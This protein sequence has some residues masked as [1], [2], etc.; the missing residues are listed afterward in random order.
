MTKPRRSGSRDPYYNV[1][2]AS[3]SFSNIAAVLA[4]FALAAVILVVQI[5]DLPDKANAA[6]LRDWATIAFLVALFGCVAS[7]FTFGVLTG[8][9]EPGSRSHAAALFGGTGFAVSTVF[10]FWGLAS[11]TK[12]FLSED[13][14]ELTRW[15]FFGTILIVPLHLIFSAIDAIRMKEDTSFSPGHF[16]RLATPSYL[17]I[18]SAI[19]LSLIGIPPLTDLLASAFRPIA[20]ISFTVIVVSAAGALFVS[21]RPVDYSLNP[22]F[23][24]V[25][26]LVQSAILA[27]LA[28]LT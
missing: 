17:L 3:Q 20:V 14:V 26:I 11:L 22:T 21:E 24:R 5:Q 23:G 28:L 18:T 1:V 13:I 27:L 9:A 8:E 7:A 2:K 19:I 16:L 4:G 6:T 12:I 25:W 10:V 15:L